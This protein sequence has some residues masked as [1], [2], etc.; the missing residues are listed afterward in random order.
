MHCS[1]I[2]F[3]IHILAI[4]ERKNMKFKAL[5]LPFITL[6]SLLISFSVFQYRPVMHTS[7]AWQA[8]QF[9]NRQRAFPYKDIPADKYFK[10]Y[11]KVSQSL[12]K[13]NF[14]NTESW[15]TIG[16]H[17]IGGRTLALAFNPQNPNTIFAGSA[18][19][20]IWRSYT[21]GLGAQAWEIIPTGYPVLGVS[22]ISIPE[23]D[24]NTIYI[25]TGEVY[26]YQNSYGGVTIRTTRGSYGI[27]IMKST[28]YGLTWEKSLD[29]SREQ[30]RGVEVIRIN[31][32][33]PN[34]L[35]AGTTEGTYKSTDAGATW[36]LINSTIMVTDIIV[37]PSDTNMV[38]IACGNSGSAGKGIYRTTDNGSGWIQLTNGVTGNFNGKILLE[39]YKANPSTLWA[40]VGLG[41]ETGA[42]TRLLKTTDYGNTWTTLST[43]DY[44]TYQGWYS[45]FVG[46]NQNDPSKMIVGGIDLYKSTNGGINF[47][48]K[49]Y[50]Y[51]WYLGQ[52]IPPGEPEGPPD[53]SHADHHC[54]AY[55]PVNPD[56]IY[57]GNDGGVFRTTDGGETF[58]GCNGG[59]QTS[60]FYNYFASSYQDS[61]I[62]IGGL[63][64]NATAIYWG[65][66][67]WRREIGGDGTSAGI[68]PG[69]DNIMYGTYQYMSLQKSTD[70]GNNWSYIAPPGSNV[71]FVAPFVVSPSNP[72]ILYAGTDLVY[73]STN[74]GSSWNATG[75]GTFNGD[76][77][78][79]L[80]V[81]NNDQNIVYAATAPVNYAANV[82][83]TTNGG[84]N[85]IN[86][87]QNLPNRYPMDIDVNPDDPNTAYI[88][89]S[90][91]GTS[92][93]FKTTDA[94]NTWIDKGAQLPDVPTSAVIIDPDYPDRVYVGNDLG[95]FV[96]LDGGDSWQSF[97]D[98][99]VDA[100]IVM[101]L[102]ISFTNRKLRCVTHGSGVFERP[103]ISG[104]VPVELTSFTA[105][106][107]DENVI[108]K[109][110]TSTE[111]N[112][113]RF[114]IQKSDDRNNFYTI[115]S[116]K[117][118]GTSTQSHS[119]SYTDKL[120]SNPDGSLFYRLKQID[121]NG[122]STYSKILTIDVDIPAV[123]N[124]SQNYPNPFNPSTVISYSI[125]V[126]SFVTIE[127][128]NALGQKIRTLVNS[129]KEAG[130]Y[131]V[132]FNAENLP[133][134]MYLYK[135]T[136]DMFSET[137]K[138]LLL[139]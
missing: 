132:N 30:Q 93:L 90:G 18:S 67:Y 49:S 100:V 83:R 14:L 107:S 127:I 75:S 53:Y 15:E 106:L 56:I 46:I 74:K 52:A 9:W 95:V 20:G 105:R 38:W 24:T 55:D 27:G 62:A 4:I 110:T 17:N 77:L 118:A 7:G 122:R 126:K 16:P 111:T 44:A 72:Q 88:V 2:N 63:Q 45:H 51:L 1:I 133:S 28:D 39:I 6:V 61:L 8:L 31:P 29:W 86:I 102:N 43:L 64:D 96:S 60:Q 135:L 68:D 80:S 25:G 123:F 57:F 81:A 12:K 139:K 79:T 116:V 94:G 138:M 70:Q 71:S 136:A 121:L 98:G 50:W 10:E 21:S 41:S 117:G 97:S 5:L 54:I 109:W 92:H 119:Y 101:D 134:G 115:G 129:Q 65:T 103:L 137:R 124:L 36:Q 59:Y 40:S 125:P 91:F 13:S 69:N 73:K 58:S 32:L 85:W 89:F 33:N 82:Y 113:D 48:Q 76:P 131:T 47:T 130:S 104:N 108:L 128:F 11:E 37:N 22:A 99:L 78:L 42:G 34:T 114:E 19:G 87:T 112:N 23:N 120:S 26:N 3:E 84:S 35:W 66:D